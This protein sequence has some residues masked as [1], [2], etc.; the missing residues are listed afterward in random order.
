MYPQEAEMCQ[1]KSLG[2]DLEQQDINNSVTTVQI[3][4]R[5]A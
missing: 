4:E 5:Q 1:K 3:M 2:H